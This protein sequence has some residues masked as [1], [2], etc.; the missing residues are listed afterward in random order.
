MKVLI[1]GAGGFVGHHALIH[2]LK[3]TDWEFVATDSFN[4]LGLSARLRAVFEE[5]P[6]A[7]NRVKVVTHDLSTPIDRFTSAEFG[8]INTI[9]NYASNANVD[10]SVQ[11]PVPFIQNNI[12]LALTM[13][14]YARTLD[15]LNCFIQISTDEVYGAA[16]KNEKH[17]EWQPLMPSNPYS[18]SKMGQEA[19]ANAYWRTYNVPVV[20]TNSMNMFGQRQQDRAFIPKTIGY[21]LQNKTMPIH[22]SR[23]NDEWVM[24]SRHYLH[25]RSQAD[26]VKFLIERF[27]DLKYRYIDGVEKLERFNIIG[28]TKIHND[29]LVF[30]IADMLKI[31]SNSLVEYV[32]VESVRPGWDPHYALDGQKLTNAGWVPPKTF[33]K[34]LEETVLWSK[35][36]AQWVI[37]N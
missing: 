17:S 13:F 24:G 2:L 35:K 36:N 23:I 32:D 12:N 37:G 21:L 28:E 22:A 16:K 30:L 25:A 10:T 15:T 1:T 8:K 33:E 5:V 7:K 3:T 26:A 20:I 31:K 4:H 18:A 27:K 34:S 9:I 11:N 29:E 19:I 6:E 14:E